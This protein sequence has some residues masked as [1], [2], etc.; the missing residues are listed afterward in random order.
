M[1]L[2]H[3]VLAVIASIAFCLGA[4]ITASQAVSLTITMERMSTIHGTPLGE[5]Q[6]A[7]FWAGEEID[8]II[9]NFEDTTPDTSGDQGGAWFFDPLSTWTLSGRGSGATINLDPNANALKFRPTDW[10]I[11]ESVSGA[12]GSVLLSIDD[13]LSLSYAT[14]PSGP[15]V[16]HSFLSA[17]SGTVAENEDGAWNVETTTGEQ[18]LSPSASF[19]VTVT[20]DPVPESGPTLLF[21]ACSLVAIV[22]VKRWS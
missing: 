16:L 21:F 2:N 6:T 4:P 5:F 15:N 11:G 17:I 22:C 3:C 1:R 18:L 14:I 12:G 7:G 19:S 20:A 9:S 10:E 13:A 8:F